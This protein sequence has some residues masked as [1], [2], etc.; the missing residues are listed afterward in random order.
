MLRVVPL[1][2]PDRPVR[3]P[4]AQISLSGEDSR[5]ARVDREHRWLDLVCDRGE[6]H[7]ARLAERRRDRLRADSFRTR[8]E[9]Q[10]ATTVDIPEGEGRGDRALEGVELDAELMAAEIGRASCRGRG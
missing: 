4:R 2:P 9:A 6:D 5:D 10:V 7:R 1:A 3:I 8:L